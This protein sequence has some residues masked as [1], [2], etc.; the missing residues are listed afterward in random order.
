MAFVRTKNVPFFFRGPDPERFYARDFK[1]WGLETGG[2]KDDFLV[3]LKLRKGWGVR[4]T[5]SVVAVPIVSLILFESMG[6]AWAFFNPDEKFIGHWMWIVLGICVAMLIAFF[7]IARTEVRYFDSHPDD[8]LT[9]YPNGKFSVGDGERL[10][11]LA[12]SLLRFTVHHPVLNSQGGSA[13][14]ELDLV[15]RDGGRVVQVYKLLAYDYQ[16]LGRHF[17][18]LSKLAGLPLQRLALQH[19]GSRFPDPAPRM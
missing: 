17:K 1:R 12:G 2:E 6:L 9:I 7:L 10:D 3:K 13:R 5:V 19:D 18:E 15:I 14:S 16:M 8:T 11:L 4:E